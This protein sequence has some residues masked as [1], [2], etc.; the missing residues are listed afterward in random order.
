[1]TSRAD[2]LDTFEFGDL[3][4]VL[5]PALPWKRIE[6][7]EPATEVT[8]MASHLPL[9]S[10]RRI[11]A[12]LAA[13]LRIRRQ[14]ARTPGL[15]GYTLDAK[16][17]RRAFWTVSAWRS[18]EDLGA[19]AA[20]DPHRHDVGNIRPHMEPTT[21][22]FWTTTAADLPIGWE[23]VRRRIAAPPDAAGG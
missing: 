1:V 17:T 21:F 19:F 20:A 3:T 4:E 23:E 12:F 9:R 14:L 6:D 5:M 7:V 2:G 15:I 11:P 13:T 18:R 22:V 8:V 16:L 10:Y